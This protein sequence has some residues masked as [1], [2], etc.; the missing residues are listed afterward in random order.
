MS[1][2]FKQIIYI[3]NFIKNPNEIFKKLREE[4]EWE[5]PGNNRT[6]YYVNDYPEPYSYKIYDGFRTYNPKPYHVEILNIRKTIENFT[7]CIFETCFLNRYLNQKDWLNWH[8]DDSPEMDPNK[9]I[10]IGSL[11]VARKIKF[12]K[13]QKKLNLNIMDSKHNENNPKN[14][15]SF[16]ECFD[17][18]LE[19]GSICIMQKGMQQKYQHMIPKA[20]FVTDKTIGADWH[21][22]ERISLTYRGFLTKEMRAIDQ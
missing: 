11:G 9:S 13:I 17:L 8:S 12:Q 22:G 3:P 18:T 2:L 4:L 5:R 21:L 6:E 16:G 7:K 19:N 20:G 1:E 14:D 15:S 10:V